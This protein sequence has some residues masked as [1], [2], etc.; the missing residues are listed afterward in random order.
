M[1]GVPHLEAIREADYL[2]KVFYLT[3][4][5]NKLVPDLLLVLRARVLCATAFLSPNRI[6][7]LDEPTEGLDENNRSKLCKSILVIF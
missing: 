6:V 4:Y 1:K 3:T 7:L 5:A 2:M